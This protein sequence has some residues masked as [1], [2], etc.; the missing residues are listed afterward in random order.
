MIK[1]F[2]IKKI[3]KYTMLLLVVFLFYLFPKKNEYELTNTVI[4]NHRLNYHDVFLLDRNN[5]LSKITIEVAAKNE[6]DLIDE[7]IE[8][9]KEDGRYIDKIPNG[10]RP[11]LPSDLK[12]NSKKIKNDIL[13][14]NFSNELLKGNIQDEE[15]IVEGLI[16]TLTSIKNIKKVKILIDGEELKK[17]PKS[18]KEL[19][20]YLK[21]DFGINKV[22]NIEN[23]KDITKVIVYYVSKNN[24]NIYYIPV[25]K[26]INSS[27]EKIKI[28]IDELTSKMSYNSDLMSYLNYNAKLL[29]YNFNNDSITLNFNEYLF[30]NEVNKKV[31][32]EVIY[33][34]SYS[35]KDNYGV[36]KINF[37]V[38]NTEIR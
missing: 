37:C 26:Y 36:S 24:D 31:L 32:E 11:F 4:K 38:N 10:F 33:S 6:L 9:M 35:I 1:K 3:C 21:R 2:S 34:I 5:Y 17:L 14:I 22:Y 16:Y 20:E 18:G 13:I 12:I 30:D 23:L 27:E 15:R 7:L 19:D 29:N 25:T 28:I 8:I